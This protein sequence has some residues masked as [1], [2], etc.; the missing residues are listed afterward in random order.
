MRRV[1]VD[2]SVLVSALLFRGPVS[3]LA[4]LWR[5]RELLLVVSEDILREYAR[6]LAYPKFRLDAGTAE[7]IMQESVLPYCEVV[8]APVLEHVCRDP[9]DDMFLA[10]ALAGRGEAIIAG[11]RDLLSLGDYQGIPILGVAQ[12]LDRFAGIPGGN[13]VTDPS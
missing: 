5:S 1:V 8:D 13:G 12:A 2:T 11:D 6:V 3:A 4:S 10:C 9:E 7:A